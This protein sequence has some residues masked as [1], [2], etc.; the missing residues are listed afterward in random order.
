MNVAYSDQIAEHKRLKKQTTTYSSKNNAKD[1][2]ERNYSEDSLKFFEMQLNK[3]NQILNK[4]KLVCIKL[5][6]MFVLVPYTYSKIELRMRN[7]LMN[8]RLLLDQISHFTHFFLVNKRIYDIVMDQYTQYVKLQQDLEYEAKFKKD[9]NRNNMDIS[10]T[11]LMDPKLSSVS[12]SV[13]PGSNNYT[14][15]YS[16][17]IQPPVSGSLNAP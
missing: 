4:A 3:S 16:S 12:P 15:N 6:K 17:N 5:D 11:Q 9:K 13:A 14:T 8:N 2:L 7:M 10:Q 1:P